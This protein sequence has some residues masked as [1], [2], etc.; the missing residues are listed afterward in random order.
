MK[1]RDK[2]SHQSWHGL[3]RVEH[4]EETAGTDP[5]HCCMKGE[6]VLVAS[7]A[8]RALHRPT[9]RAGKF[10]GAACISRARRRGSWRWPVSID[11]HGWRPLLVD[12]PTWFMAGLQPDRARPVCRRYGSWWI[13]WRE[14][15]VK[16][17]RDETEVLW[18]G[19]GAFGWVIPGWWT[20]W[21]VWP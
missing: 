2:R 11:G 9:T 8:S 1:T 20:D 5:R 19:E 14:K 3:V 12:I 10:E 18:R 16:R 17:E 7:P 6:S 21:M 4:L 13:D 15:G